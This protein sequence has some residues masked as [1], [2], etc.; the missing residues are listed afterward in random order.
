MMGTVD[1]LKDMCGPGIELHSLWTCIIS[2]ANNRK[3][4]DLTLWLNMWFIKKGQQ[5][6]HI[7]N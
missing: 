6:G 1:A 4:F 2:D 5:V 3:V 7:A